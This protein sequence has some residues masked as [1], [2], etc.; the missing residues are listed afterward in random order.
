M[1]APS[2]PRPLAKAVMV[3]KTASDNSSHV[4]RPVTNS[5][6]KELKDTRLRSQTLQTVHLPGRREVEIRPAHAREQPTHKKQNRGDRGPRNTEQLKPNFRWWGF[7][8]LPQTFAQEA[9]K[10]QDEASEQF[11]TMCLGPAWAWAVLGAEGSEMSEIRPLVRS[12]QRKDT[13]T[14]RTGPSATWH[15]RTEAGIEP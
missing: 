14:S 13:G 6:Q 12:S 15:V 10:P 7:E 9:A 2:P 4:A 3:G 1:S 8:L 11:L 5:V